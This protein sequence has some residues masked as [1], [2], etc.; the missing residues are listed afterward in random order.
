M[1]KKKVMVI[2]DDEGV[3]DVMKTILE[4]HGYNVV[5]VPN[6]FIVK[7]I[8]NDFP[9][10]F[11]VDVWMKECDGREICRYLKTQADTK[12]IPVIM[13]SAARN[14]IKSAEQAGANDF[15][16]KPFDIEDLIKKVQK[17]I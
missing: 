13:V 1:T 17:L 6:A 5:I 12:H 15:L 14:L 8:K 7:D 10:L 16:E 9:D 3:A 2:E 4:M 11:L